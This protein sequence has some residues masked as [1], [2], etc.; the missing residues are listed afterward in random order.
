VL[1]PGQN[2]LGKRVLCCEGA[3]NDPRWKTI[4]G[5]V[6]DTRSAGPEQAVELEF[7]LP[8]AQAPDQAW[9]W[10]RRTMSLVARAEREPSSLAPAM[11]EALR[12][13]DPSVPVYRIQTFES[14]LS[15]ALGPAR[16]RTILLSSLAGI[17]LLLALVGIYGVIAYMV[18]RRRPEIGVR[19]A[20][21]ASTRD[22]LRMVVGQGLRPVLA[23]TVVGAIGALAANRLLASWL[24]G[25]SPTDPVSFGL[26][27]VVLVGVATLA[28]LI[29]ARRATRVSALE[30]MRTE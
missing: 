4:V 30:A 21:G 8:I 1:F 22:V 15:R 25:V 5:V 14:S 7:Y 23:G 26:V 24:H 29:P 11:R 17:G 6:G 3:L 12:R 20:L 27:A 10:I 16:F 9:S 18:T 13:V 19:M 28:S 2:P